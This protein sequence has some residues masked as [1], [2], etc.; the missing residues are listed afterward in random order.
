MKKGTTFGHDHYHIFLIYLVLNQF[1]FLI[2]LK[3]GDIKKKAKPTLSKKGI[4][5]H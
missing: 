1:L 4:I 2:C 3:A 5:V